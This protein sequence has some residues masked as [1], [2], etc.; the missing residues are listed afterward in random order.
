MYCNDSADTSL[1]TALV[2]LD[3]KKDGNRIVIHGIHQKRKV[4]QMAQAWT[5]EWRAVTDPAY[6][7][8]RDPQNYIP[9]KPPDFHAL[10]PFRWS[11][12]GSGIQKVWSTRCF[13][14]IF[15][16]H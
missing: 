1:V 11:L 2:F 13:L 6:S 16:L 7:T 8:F 14:L 3:K 15:N 4:W 5:A 12:D 9:K 10:I